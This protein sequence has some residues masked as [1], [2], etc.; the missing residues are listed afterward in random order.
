M[1]QPQFKEILQQKLDET[2]EPF[3]AALIDAVKD[4]FQFVTHC[5]LREIERLTRKSRMTQADYTG[6]ASVPAI[7]DKSKT[8]FFSLSLTTET[9]GKMIQNVFPKEMGHAITDEN[10]DL[11]LSVL[12]AISRRRGD[13]L[14]SFGWDLRALAP[15]LITGRD[16]SIFLPTS[17]TC[18]VNVCECRFGAVFLDACVYPSLEMP[19]TSA[20][21][22]RVI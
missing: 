3:L 17:I 5:D 6:M 8:L 10:H 13:A 18:H 16:H 7:N 4:A 15:T 11:L 12:R 2:Q 9:Y 21:L 1:G 19:A 20:R 14:S 22:G